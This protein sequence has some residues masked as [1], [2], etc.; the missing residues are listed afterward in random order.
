VNRSAAPS[1]SAG[2]S[3]ATAERVAVAAALRRLPRSV[4]RRIRPLLGRRYAVG[5][6]LVRGR[7]R[8]GHD[9]LLDLRSPVQATAYFSG[10]YDDVLLTL[11][12]RLLDRPGAIAVDVGA[13][14]GFWTV[15]LAATVAERG[16][17]VF[18]F[19]PV[20]ANRERL[21]ENVTVND[22]RRH[23]RVLD[24]A[25]SDRPGSVAVSLRE[26]FLAGSSTGNAAVVIGA[27]DDRFQQTVVTTAR[28][29]ELPDVP[30]DRIGFVK[31]D[32]EG[33]EDQVLRGARE[34]LAEGRPVVLAEWNPVY[35]RRRR[36]DPTT[37]V[38]ATL[39]PLEYA[40]LRPT[41]AGWRLTP[42][43]WSPKE[44]DNLLLVPQERLTEVVDRVS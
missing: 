34:T 29:D 31:I 23:V 41:R 10:R 7:M 18:A 21:H 8:L 30:T 1:P 27:D 43:F 28:L 44:L 40:T 36:I 35:Y 20:P 26:E 4:T 32:V 39:R 3:F 19:E 24:V 14:I 25:L 42:G 5:G 17:Q 38:D 16:G 12:R 33:H 11:A 13:N 6:P 22:L 15:P 37:A 2:R 9:L